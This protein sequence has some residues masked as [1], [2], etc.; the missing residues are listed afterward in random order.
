MS[1]AVRGP[2][3]AHP[4][5]TGPHGR[6]ARWLPG[7]RPRLPTTWCGS[8]WQSL[9]ANVPFSNVDDI[10]AGSSQKTPAAE[11]PLAHDSASRLRCPHTKRHTSNGRSHTDVIWIGG[12][13]ESSMNLYP[14]RIHMRANPQAGSAGDIAGARRACGVGPVAGGGGGIEVTRTT[15][16]FA[17]TAPPASPSSEPVARAPALPSA[18]SPPT[19]TTRGRPAPRRVRGF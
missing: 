10:N 12:R 2:L 1:P 4:P 6:T 14:E 18:P 13:V 19:T 8:G 16:E 17:H 15:G 7:S 3:P 5:R 9:S 11:M